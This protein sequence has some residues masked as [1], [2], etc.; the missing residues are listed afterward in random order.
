MATRSSL[1]TD[2]VDG[3]LAQQINQAVEERVSEA[4]G[5][6][7]LMDLDRTDR[8]EIEIARRRLDALTEAKKKMKPLL[9]KDH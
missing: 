8:A 4:G 3:G 9:R 6:L 7:P 5:L 2:L 1:A